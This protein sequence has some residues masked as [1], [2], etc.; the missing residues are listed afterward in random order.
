MLVF[1]QLFT[2]FKACCSVILYFL[3]SSSFHVLIKTD[4][5]M[6]YFSSKHFHQNLNQTIAQNNLL[7]FTFHRAAILCQEKNFIACQCKV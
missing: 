3:G 5:E 2:F 6:K 1:Q 4:F 7:N